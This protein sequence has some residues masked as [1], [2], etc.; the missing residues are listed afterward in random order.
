MHTKVKNGLV[1]FWEGP[2]SNF[3]AVKGCIVY[4]NE[5][6]HTSE[7]IFM[8]EKANFFEDDEIADHILTKCRNP[9]DAKSAGRQ[10]AN[11]DDV[12]WDAAR[13]DFM[14]KACRAKYSQSEHHKKEL[15]KYGACG[16]FVEASPYD[17]IWGI[18]LGVDHQDAATPAKWKGLNLLGLV[19]DQIY[20]EMKG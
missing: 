12:K 11:Y 4:A 3:D 1:L 6:F 14:L 19:L 16:K 13:Y 8:W 15:L 2:F 7:Q 20:D 9:M 5:R 10:I 18:G 17:K